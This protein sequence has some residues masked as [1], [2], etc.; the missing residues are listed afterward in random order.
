[1]GGGVS[2]SEVVNEVNDMVA[3]I[4]V[5]IALF[6]NTDDI[7]TQTISIDCNPAPQANS[8]YELNGGCSEC[9]QGV[10]DSHKRYYTFQRQAWE[11]GDQIPGVAKPIDSD[12][13][14]VI[15]EFVA[16]TTTHCKACVAENLSQ[17]TLI[18]SVLSCDAFNNVKNSIS[19]PNRI[20]AKITDNVISNITQQISSNQSIVIN[21]QAGGVTMQQGLSQESAF[22]SVQTYLSRT[23]LFNSIL[24]SEQWTL[25][26]KLANEQNTIGSLGNTIVKA[27]KY[28]SKLLTNV[29]GKVVLFVM[30]MVGVIFV[31]ILIYVSSKLIRKALKKQHDHDIMEKQ[32]AEE[33]PAFETF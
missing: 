33:L 17:K 28:L 23:N 15:N 6:C 27:V 10:V 32:K 19:Q 9:I 26:Q 30:I 16:C 25:L 7:A 11:R 13:Q 5:N 3:D 21:N 29:V 20:S 4:F 31:G 14:A 18:K 2:Q 24:S 1:M 22:H 12:F 8:I